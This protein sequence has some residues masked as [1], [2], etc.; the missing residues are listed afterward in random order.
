MRVLFSCSVGDGHLL[1]LVPLARA[2]ADRGDDVAF[3][4]AAFYRDRVEADGFRLLPAGL[5]PAEL[6]A[7][8]AP[9]RE[10]LLEL[11]YGERRPY[12]FSWRFG[13]LSAPAKLPALIDAVAAWAPDLVVHEAADLAAPIAAA[14]AGIAS[15]HHGFGRTVPVAVFESATR[16]TDPLWAAHGLKPEPLGGVYRGTY[17]AICPPAIQGELPPDGVRVERL[18]P[19]PLP[20][21]GAA[22]G[23]LAG[24]PDRPTVYVTLGTVVNT[25]ERFRVVLDGLAELDCNVVATIGRNR[26]PSALEPV[27]ANAIVQQYVPQAELLPHCG[28]VVAH[29]GSGST[30]GALAHG[31]PMLLL[32]TAADQFE[33][34]LACRA[35]GVARVLLPDAVDAAAVR[36]EVDALLG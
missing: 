2:F 18:R 9:Y 29:G 23:R 28:V 36:T 1:P 8:Y 31:V 27:P 20:S 3:T 14:A 26:D 30:L 6:E 21:P 10:R 13:R 5:E 24:L 19:C 22:P 12:A 4:T 15:V 17:V 33:N 7:L 11:P 34:A 35:A 32:P 25:V 16:E